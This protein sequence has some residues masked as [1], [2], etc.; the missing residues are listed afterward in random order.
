MKV[1]VYFVNCLLACIIAYG[2]G[3]W[4]GKRATERRLSAVLSR[5]IG[6]GVSVETVQVDSPTKH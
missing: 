2:A 3:Y 5:I 4:F 1:N 6:G